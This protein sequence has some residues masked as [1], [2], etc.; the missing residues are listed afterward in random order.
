MIYKEQLEKQDYA[1]TILAILFLESYNTG[2]EFADLTDAQREE[3]VFKYM[4]DLSPELLKVLN[5]GGD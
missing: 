1:L 5:R 2:V 3:D 4:Q